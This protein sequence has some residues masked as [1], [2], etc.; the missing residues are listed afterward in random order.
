[1]KTTTCLI[2]LPALVL[3]M[4]AEARE[5]FSGIPPVSSQPSGQE[6]AIA[7]NSADGVLAHPLV[8][9]AGD[10]QAALTHALATRRQ[11]K[12]VF[13]LRSAG[14][15]QAIT[16]KCDVTAGRLT[17]NGATAEMPPSAINCRFHEAGRTQAARLALRDVSGSETA[18]ASR[19]GE[20]RVD[21]LT[22]RIAARAGH[23]GS[24]AATPATSG[25]SA[26]VFSVD[27]VDVGSVDLAGRPVVHF[28][29]GHD[30]RT[31][32]AVM[33]AATALGV[34]WSPQPSVPAHLAD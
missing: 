11:G 33:L 28:V 31:A 25:P 13:S 23:A 7:G 19:H 8:F 21:G 5:H 3:A 6:A 17:G 20:L 32:R 15:E 1:M 9:D 30:S 4:K 12:V 2:V 26:Y 34:L 22:V 29:P 18:S 24:G 16:A 14:S 27:G 10:A